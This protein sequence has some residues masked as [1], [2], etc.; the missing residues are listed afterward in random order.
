M[1][2]YNYIYKTTNLISGN[3]YV[4][5]HTSNKHPDKDKYIGSGVAFN[6]AVVKYGRY[7]FKREILEFCTK[8]NLREKESYWI[9][10]L[11]VV[12]QGYNLTEKSSGGNLESEA[13]QNRFATIVTCPHCGKQSAN[14]PMMCRIHF[15]NC[16]SNPNVDLEEL[17]IRKK[18]RDK[19]AKET[20]DNEPIL[21][22]PYCNKQSNN[23]GVMSYYHFDNCKQNPNY[24]DR[25][26][27][28]TCPYCGKQGRGSG[29]KAYH[30]DK[31][32]L[33]PNYIPG[34][35]KNR[36][37]KDSVREFLVKRNASDEWKDNMTMK[38]KGIPKTDEHKQ[39]FRDS[40]IER[41]IDTYPYCGKQGKKSGGFYQQH[42]DYC[43]KNPNRVD[44]KKHSCIYCGLET[45]NKT[46]ITRFHNEN[47]KHKPKEQE[48][49]QYNLK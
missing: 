36:I 44:K 8:E 38:L 46:I 23:T 41:E 14:K 48:P 20:A 45:E 37:M 4:G 21:I 35:A 2:K 15:D 9:R 33:A 34:Q 17:R 13:Y 42:F 16:L 6:D 18:K 28:L 10:Q 7:S 24:I 25:R 30:F 31:C 27:L 47:C 26:K 3:F 22:C 1:N 12:K 11:D 19:K 32:K 43:K 5:R 40:W 39:H 49:I 29:I